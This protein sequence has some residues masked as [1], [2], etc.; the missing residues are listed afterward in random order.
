MSI[1]TGGYRNTALCTP[2]KT[3][4]QAEGPSDA[5]Q[6]A[7]GPAVSEKEKASPAQGPATSTFFMGLTVMGP[8]AGEGKQKGKK[9]G[10]RQ[11]EAQNHGNRVNLS[12]AINDFKMKCQCWAGKWI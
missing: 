1:S 11:D 9:G 3:R 6:G 12:F 5:A 4:L 8:C 10:N 7:A 2:P